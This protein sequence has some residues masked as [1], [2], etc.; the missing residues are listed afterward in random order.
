MQ[1]QQTRTQSAEFLRVAVGHM[2][3]QEAA[4]DPASYTL[5]YEHV[6]GLNPPLSQILEQRLTAQHPLTDADVAHLYA[7]YIASREAQAVARIHE[8]LRV[9]MAETSEVITQSGTHA[10]QFGKSLETHTERLRKPDAANA[11]HLV[12]GELL[13]ETQKMSSVSLTLTRQ[14]DT[15]AKEV[16]TLTA[17]LERAEAAAFNDSLTGLL[18]R[19]GL[20]K[21]FADLGPRMASQEGTSLLLVD[22]DRFKEINDAYGHA[23]G[24][25][26]LRGVAQI[27]RAR[28]KGADIAARVGGDEFAIL[29]P[30]TASTGARALAEKIRSTLFQA[31]LRRTGSD[32]QIGQVS[33]SVGVAHSAEVINIDQFMKKADGAL[34]AAKREGRNRVE[35]AK[36]GGAPP[37]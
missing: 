13:V 34:Y 25:Q 26:V 7:T 37:R 8:R 2:G 23:V 36:E 15:R 6:A 32:E 4:L 1:Y 27:L 20:E 28:I 35:E 24:D 10:T 12:L 29:L 17:R 30:D 14:L 5:W 22:V 11:I 16:Q 21:A 18:N 3:R 31:R 9:L 33:I 19:R